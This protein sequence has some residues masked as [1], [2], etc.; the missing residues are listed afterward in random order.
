MRLEIDWIKSN[1][2]EIGGIFDDQ[3]TSLSVLSTSHKKLSRRFRYLQYEFKKIVMRTRG[4][5]FYNKVLEE[6]DK[7]NK[8]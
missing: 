4:V 8:E 2:I 1:K 5:E 6:M 7:K 3:V